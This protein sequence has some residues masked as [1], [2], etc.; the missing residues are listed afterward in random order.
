MIATFLIGSATLR[1]G[2]SANEALAREEPLFETPVSGMVEP[3]SCEP[4]EDLR[5]LMAVFEERE[6]RIER[7]EAEIK[8]RLKALDVADEEVNRKLAALKGAEERLRSLIAMAETA[9]EDDVTQLTQV[10]ETMKP[11]SVAALF[12]EMDPTF[13]AGFIA[14][15]KPEAAAGVMAGMNPEAAYSISVIL[16]G[17]NANTPTE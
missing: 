11:K 6:T 3:Q 15:M 12:E 14:R 16:A 4:P 7:R 1:V 13:A 9:A 5:E 17:R 8:K 10:Y 2:I